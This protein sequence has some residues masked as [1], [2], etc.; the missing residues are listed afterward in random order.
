[1]YFEP[2]IV[3]GVVDRV[4]GLTVL[5][6]EVEGWMVG[7]AGGRVSSGAGGVV[8]EDGAG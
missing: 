8:V 4:G 2:Y 5:P 6:S 7:W 3:H 1:M